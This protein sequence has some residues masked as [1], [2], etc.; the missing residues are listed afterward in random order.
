MS[1]NTRVMEPHITE[2]E[3]DM[4]EFMSDEKNV[5]K[6]IKLG[7]DLSASGV[8]GI[9]YRVM[10]AAGTEGVKFM[11]RLVRA[12]IRSGRVI[13]SW[14]EA[15]TILMHRK[16]DR[17]EIENGR[18]FSITDCM[19]RIFTCLMQR[20]FQKINSKAHMF[21]D[22]QKG[23]IQKI[24]G[25]SEHG[26]MSNELLHNAHRNREGL[27]LTAIDFINAFGSVRH[28]LIMSTMQERNF[29]EWM[30]KI[31]SDM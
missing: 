9:S 25:G 6:V 18:L 31:V 11:K 24:N 4:E 29:R 5:V 23:F 10:K 15:K 26:I 8:D 13:S 21:S 30:Q 1:T 3:E 16:G 17:D 28:E 7:E 22:G 27:V 2:R 20:A 19:S 14:R 12:S